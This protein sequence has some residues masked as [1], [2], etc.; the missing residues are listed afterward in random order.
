MDLPKFDRTA[1]LVTRPCFESRWERRVRQLCAV[2]K[3]EYL[4]QV[5]SKNKPN[6][7]QAV[8]RNNYLNTQDCCCTLGSTLQRA[9]LGSFST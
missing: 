5:R 2:H 3:A 9:V 6:N 7:K 4:L 8:R 1:L